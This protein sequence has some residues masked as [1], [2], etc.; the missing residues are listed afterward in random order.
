MKIWI[1]LVIVGIVV[2]SL[3]L[4]Q[5]QQAPDYGAQYNSE[6]ILYSTSW[7]T[8]CRATRQYLTQQGIPYLEFDI[9][10]SSKAYKEHKSLGGRGV[11]VV[12]VKGVVIQGYNPNALSRAYGGS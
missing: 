4:M 1:P 8:S 11:P 6:V 2:F 7:C 12:L 5:T 3:Q 10:K 9:E